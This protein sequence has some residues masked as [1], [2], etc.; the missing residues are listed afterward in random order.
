MDGL[1]TWAIENLGTWV[2]DYA[3]LFLIIA[4]AL[5]VILLITFIIVACCHA[6]NKKKINALKVKNKHLAEEAEN[7]GGEKDSGELRAQIR[8]ELE[9]I[10]REQVER[11]YANIPVEA[12]SDGQADR[13]IAELENDNREKQARID[14]L[15]DALNRY[16]SE[17]ADSHDL[18]NTVNELNKTN[19]NLEN[20]MNKLKAENAQMKAQSLQKQLDEATRANSEAARTAPTRTAR[21]SSQQAQQEQPQKQAPV[22]KKPV[23]VETPPDDDDEDE[24]YDEYGDETSAV[25]VTLKFD[26]VK[27][28]WVILRTDTDRAYRRLATKQEALVVAKDLARRLH[29]Q[30]VVH[31]KDGK[32]QRI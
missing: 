31:K 28:N 16:S 2:T 25:K 26:R 14:S 24:Y 15:T 22:R 1:N 7:A 8:A 6:K 29:A 11:E 19:R 9:P 32:F 20:E 23:V 21:S 13:R 3:A 27:N 5:V 4:A 12:Q 10:I 30:L 18:Q 17:R